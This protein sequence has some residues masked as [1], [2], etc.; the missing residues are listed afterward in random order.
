MLLFAILLPVI[1]GMVGLLYSVGFIL[2]ERRAL[3]T[4]ADAASTAATWQVLYELESGDRSDA[5]VFVQA[6]KYAL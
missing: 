5:K 2:I 6:Q 1:L 4:A 3:Q